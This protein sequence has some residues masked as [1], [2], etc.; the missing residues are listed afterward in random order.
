LISDIKQSVEF[1]SSDRVKRVVSI[2]HKVVDFIYNSIGISKNF[3]EKSI[4]AIE[5]F[6]SEPASIKDATFD[7]AVE[8]VYFVNSLRGN[9]II[10]E[11]INRKIC[12][13]QNNKRKRTKHGS[14][15]NQSLPTPDRQEKVCDN[16]LHK[17]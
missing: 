4:I 1:N 11:F 12:A 15:T 17:R 7:K 8:A 10:I 9:D 6:R 5:I 2:S 16:S 13:G 3:A 14:L